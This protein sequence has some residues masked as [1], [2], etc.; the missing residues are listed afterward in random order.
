MRLE[1]LLVDSTKDSSEELLS[2]RKYKAICPSDIM[3]IIG[4]V[5]YKVD[6]WR[7]RD[8]SIK[9]M[10]G[11]VTQATLSGV[12]RKGLDARTVPGLQSWARARYATADC[13]LPK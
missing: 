7:S 5:R 11:V 4:G 1:A 12:A 10:E 8:C 9:S 2:H 13:T 3:I 6:E